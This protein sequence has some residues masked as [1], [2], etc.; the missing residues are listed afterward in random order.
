MARRPPPL[1]EISIGKD[2]EFDGM[3][4][5]YRNEG[6]SVSASNL[7]IKVMNDTTSSKHYQLQLQ[8]G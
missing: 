1:L 7:R 6:I 8:L 2:D 4:Q 5:T 3:G